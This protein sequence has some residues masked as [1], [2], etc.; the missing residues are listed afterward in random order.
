MAAAGGGM[1]AA[2]PASAVA[3]SKPASPMFDSWQCPNPCGCTCHHSKPASVPHR[4]TRQETTRVIE[5]AKKLSLDLREKWF[6]GA[7]AVPHDDDAH[8]E[9][10]ALLEVIDVLV[11]VAAAGIEVEDE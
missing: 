4:I 7:Q 11:Y 5:V 1:G 8:Q 2:Q 6:D 9:V 10:S 3:A